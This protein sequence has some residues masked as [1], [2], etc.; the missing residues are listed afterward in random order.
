MNRQPTAIAQDLVLIGGGHSHAIAL[1][2]LG[3]QPLPGV[4]ITLI[5]NLSH[6]PY[7][8]MLPGLVAGLYDFDEAH[9]D[10]RPLSQFA[11]ARLLIDQAVGLDLAH[12]RVICAQRPPVAF[13]YLSI[14]IGSTPAQVEV[15][16]AADYAIPAKPVPQLLQAWQ[17]WLT[18]IQADPQ[19]SRRLVIV[20]G[21][22]GGVELMLNMQARLQ[23]LYHRLGRSDLPIECHL[24]QRSPTLA[25]ERNRRT[26]KLLTR[27]LRDRGVQLHLADAVVEVQPGKVRSESGLQLECDRVIWVTNAAAPDWIQQSGLATDDR[28]FIAV[29]ETLQSTSHPFVFATGDIA[30]M[31]AH[32]RPKAG[33]FAV[34]QGKPLFENLTRVLTNRSP[35]PFTP[36]RQFLTL[37]GT[38]DEQA[39][40]SRWWLA[41]RSAWF[42]R[43]KDRIDRAFMTQFQDLPVMADQAPAH[44]H[45]APSPQPSMRCGGCGSKVGSSVL[46]QALARLRSESPPPYD[47]SSASDPAT[48]RDR[49]SLTAATAPILIGLDAPDDAAVIQIPPDRLLVQTVDFFRALL[50]DP[51]LF[52]EIA[53]QHALSDLFAMGAT[54]TSGLA[55]AV[56]PELHVEKQT[57]TLYQLLAG[58]LASLQAAGATLIGGHTV[59]GTE[60]SFG[61]TCNG[62]VKP[63]E[64]MRKGGLQPGQALLL[65]KPLGT[66]TLFAANMQGQAKGRWIEAA[67]ASMRQ[68]NQAAAQ[69]IQACGG[70]SCTDVTGFGLIGHLV[71]MIQA[72]DPVGVTLWLD[73]IPLL[74]GARSLCQQG[75]LSSLHPVNAQALSAVTQLTD[76]AEWPDLPLLVDPQTAGG[77]LAAIP[78]AAAATCQARLRSQGYTATAWIGNVTAPPRPPGTIT[79]QRQRD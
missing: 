56:V 14:D 45:A 5:T 75:I 21:G 16:G 28:G 29:Q 2:K 72:S 74:P 41:W 67:I 43:W 3:M 64:L 77:L 63:D 73:Q 39:I 50:D 20:G 53:T 8:G 22:A 38:G 58:A 69:I 32:P 25:A 61:M 15:P 65:T 54:P 9:I 34:R 23:R 33:V 48:T 36:Q 51:F 76:A 79:L 37:I 19:R 62:L 1:R 31:L 4:R 49:G 44:P 11:Q 35:Q 40:A 57:E 30:T 10:L 60:L 24:F 47:A 27:I 55:I 70:R 13:D 6:T 68:S 46:Q 66:G 26:Q 42:W 52:G 59:E 71:E 17:D 78:A 12:R 18:D 7:S